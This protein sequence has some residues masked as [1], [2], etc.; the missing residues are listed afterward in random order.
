M[1]APG[2]GPQV[3]LA[4]VPRTLVERGKYLTS[5]YRAQTR[6]IFSQMS[7]GFFYFLLGLSP[8]QSEKRWDFSKLGNP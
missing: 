7:L 6:L 8:D 3:H 5:T 4:P 1:V 2:S